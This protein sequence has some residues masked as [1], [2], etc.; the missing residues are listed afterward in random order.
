[1]HAEY[2]NISLSKYMTK[3]SERKGGGYFAKLHVIT[4]ITKIL[5]FCVSIFLISLAHPPPTTH[6][7]FA[8]DA[9]VL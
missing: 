6:F 4:T 2:C 9:T 1:M 7:Q 3:A 5:F 8:S